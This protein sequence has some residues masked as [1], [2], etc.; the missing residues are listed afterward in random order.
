MILEKGNK[1]YGIKN[2]YLY[3]IIIL[4]I[5]SLVFYLSMVFEYEIYIIFSV[6]NFLTWHTILEFISVIFAFIIFNNCYYSYKHTKRVRLLLLASTFFIVGSID[7]LHTLS[8]EGM[9]FT[10][11]QSSVEMATTYW[12][13][14]RLIM[15]VGIFISS[16]IPFYK[17]S[18]FNEKS[19]IILNILL[20][21]IIFHIVTYKI[22]V[23]PPLFIQGKGMTSLKIYLEY[24]IVALQILSI[25]NFIKTYEKTSNTYLIILSS[26]L[27]L[28]TFSEGLFTLYRSVYDTFN[29]LG[30]VYK[31]WGVYLIYHS[32]YKY[33]IDL[34]YKKLKEAQGKVSLYADNLEKIVNIRTEEFRKANEKLNKELDYAKVIQQSLL[35]PEKIIFENVVFNSKY[36]PCEKLSGDFYDIYEINKNNIAMYILDVTG[37]GVPAALLTMFSINNVKS[38]EKIIKRYRGLKPHKNLKNF[39]E[40][41]NKLNF[42]EEMHIVTFFATYNKPNKVLTYCSAGMN[43]YPI[44]IRRTGEYELLDKSRGFPICQLSEF[45]TPQYESAKV[46]L[47]EGDKIIF[48]TDGLTDVQKNSS[49][50]HKKLLNILVRN[51][52]SSGE[53]LNNYILKKLENSIKDFDDDI[54]YFIM[55]IL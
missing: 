53:K 11:A 25:I 16:I 29:L 15:A 3:I 33:N 31:V 9:P 20:I 52:K 35:P 47:Q 51:S 44:L 45:F 34:P 7:F 55:E 28:M 23:L 6:V 37:H 5:T 42:P 27:I 48:Y 43:C 36:I 46:Q 19:A 8:Y 13:F 41:F 21:F 4:V 17:K 39:Y 49:I 50:D 30:H 1:V 26:G 54:T 38:N 14:A 18:K 10:F 32:I 2:D 22:D 24:F 12:V 40:E